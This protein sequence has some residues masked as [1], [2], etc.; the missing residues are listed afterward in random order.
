MSDDVE[1]PSGEPVTFF[2]ERVGIIQVSGKIR[3]RRA[4]K[5]GIQ[6]E[7]LA[8]SGLRRLVM[9]FR[10]LSSIDSLGSLS[11][12]RGI[13]AGLRL[14]LVVG[15]GFDADRC[16]NLRG[17]ARR[18]VKVHRE[19]EDALQTVRGIVESGMQFA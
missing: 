11:L 18:A 6:L 12:Q 7:D 10:D 16:L 9:D 2:S 8:Q 3:G 17:L 19:L 15:P 1:P 14:H 4:R 13:D 5:L